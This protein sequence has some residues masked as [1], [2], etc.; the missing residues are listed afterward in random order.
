MKTL[1]GTGQLGADI[2]RAAL[3]TGRWLVRSVILLFIQAI[4]FVFAS[5]RGLL[6]GVIVIALLVLVDETPGPKGT[7]AI[8]ELPVPLLNAITVVELFIIAA[9]WRVA[10]GF[11]KPARRAGWTRFLSTWAAGGL[12]FAAV[13]LLASLLASV[14]R[15]PGGSADIVPA[16]AVALG[17]LAAGAVY[18]W[19]ALGEALAAERSRSA[20]RMTRERLL[21]TVA[22]RPLPVPADG[23]YGSWYVW[24]VCALPGPPAAA[25]RAA[26]AAV[27]ALR[28]GADATAA[29]DAASRSRWSPAAIVERVRS[30]ARRPDRRFP[31]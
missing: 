19:A 10:S 11:R 20:T 2:G 28:S 7:P 25:H 8:N 16:P 17:L 18:N 6:V 24:S 4:R 15:H 9:C 27:A 31:L 3:V 29:A 12:I 30:T 26:E 5:W 14:G 1:P 23:T 13:A 22:R 21:A